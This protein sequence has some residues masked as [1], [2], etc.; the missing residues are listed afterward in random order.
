MNYT[1]L[2]EMFVSD[3][4]IDM[5]K[6]FGCLVPTGI[7]DGYAGYK[8][9]SCA[10]DGVSMLFFDG[11]LFPVPFLNNELS[12]KTKSY[13]NAMSDC[14]Q[15]S[16][17][18]VAV[19]AEVL[20]PEMIDEQVTVDVIADCEECTGTGTIEWVCGDYTK[21]D[22]C[23]YC[24]GEGTIDKSYKE[25]TGKQIPNYQAAFMLD[26]TIFSY[27]VLDRLLKAAKLVGTETIVHRYFDEPLKQNYF[28]LGHGIVVLTMPLRSDEENI[29][30][31]NEGETK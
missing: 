1:E 9:Y 8:G 2:L 12:H 5:K 24:D 14:T 27:Y 18:S 6:P 17:I 20:I 26:G 22:D 10:T 7:N 3:D 31:L 28:E 21:E 23:P 4:R 29:K 15:K 19:L 16:E 11:R 13:I 25:L 30:E